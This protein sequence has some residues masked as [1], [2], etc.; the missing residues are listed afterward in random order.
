M[1]VTAFN[2]LPKAEAAIQ[3]AACCGSGK[4][5]EGMLAMIP[6]EDELNLLKRSQDIWYN[7][8]KE[9]DWREA[10]T[11]HP[12]IGDIQSLSEKFASTMHLAGDEQVAVQHASAAIITELAA[13]NTDYE[14]KFGFI[15]IVCA[16]GKSASE[17]L[18][19]L[20]DRLKNTI[21]EELQIA[22]GEQSKIT[23]L[24]LQKIFNGEE[25]KHGSVSQLTTHVLDTSVGKPGKDITVRLRTLSND[26]WQTFAQGVTNDDGRLS[27]LLP[28]ER[29]LAPGTY[30]IV[31]ETGLYFEAGKIKGFYPEVEIQFTVFDDKH[32]HVPLLINPF[33]YST[34][35]GS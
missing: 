15:F 28:P 10:F 14:T 9:T 1:N 8:C 27:D 12:K 13:A 2:A 4:W 23:A 22:M 3:L 20:R 7:E 17:M 26:S 32:Y 16:T 34:Y 18:R 31:F 33:G 24:R 6:V 35:R 11:H 5:Q 29:I 21:A 19:L 25:R 30:K